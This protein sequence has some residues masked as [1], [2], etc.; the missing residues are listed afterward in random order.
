MG[1]FAPHLAAWVALHEDGAKPDSP[2]PT[3]R[4][5]IRLACFVAL[6]APRDLTRV[7]PIELA[8]RPLRGQDF[9]NAFTASFGCTAEQFETDA[10]V[11]QRIHEASP[12]F[13]VTPGD[14]A[15]ILRFLRE[16]L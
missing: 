6:T 10:T 16:H 15:T 3:E 2:D 4:A 13:L 12:F 9:A 11:R 5:S 14:H 8:R 7:R 1:Q